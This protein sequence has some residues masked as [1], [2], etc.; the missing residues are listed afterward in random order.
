MS[1]FCDTLKLCCQ[2]DTEANSF[3]KCLIHVLYNTAVGGKGG[4]E[5]KA[6]KVGGEESGG[7]GR[8]EGKFLSFII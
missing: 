7:E 2:T 4:R 1:N 5:W 3:L 6:R 8:K